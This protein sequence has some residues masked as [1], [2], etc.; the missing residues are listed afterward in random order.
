MEIIKNYIYACESNSDMENS[1]FK[2]KNS[3]NIDILKIILDYNKCGHKIGNVCSCD[4]DHFDLLVRN[5]VD[6]SP[7]IP[8]DYAPMINIPHIYDINKNTFNSINNFIYKYEIFPSKYDSGWVDQCYKCKMVFLFKDILYRNKCM[9]HDVWEN[10][11]TYEEFDP[12]PY[13]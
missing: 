6:N 10:N 12:K 13:R 2:N 7:E 11:I 3:V 8:K 1:L 5:D 4:C 9:Y